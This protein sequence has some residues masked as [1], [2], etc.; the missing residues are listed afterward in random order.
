[1]GWV[2]NHGQEACRWC[3]AMN[4]Q[5]MTTAQHPPCEGWLVFSWCTCGLMAP[6][7]VCVALSGHNYVLYLPALLV[8]LQV[9][10]LELVRVVGERVMPLAPEVAAR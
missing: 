3:L 10:L 4:H 9:L 7:A 1:M 6:A 5:H 2:H 8:A